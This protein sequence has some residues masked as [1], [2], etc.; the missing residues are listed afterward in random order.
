MEQSLSGPMAVYHSQM[1]L[2]SASGVTH[3][4][5]PECRF[6]IKYSLDWQRYSTAAVRLCRKCSSP[7]P[8]KWQ[9]K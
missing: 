7:L 5:C 9:K 1:R 6:P 2:S 8:D 4:K 3:R